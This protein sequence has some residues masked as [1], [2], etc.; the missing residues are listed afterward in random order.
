MTVFD[1]IW[2]YSKQ[3]ER[4]RDAPNAVFFAILILAIGTALSWWAGGWNALTIVVFT[5]FMLVFASLNIYDFRAEREATKRVEELYIRRRQQASSD[6][7][8]VARRDAAAGGRCRVRAGMSE[9]LRGGH[10][11]RHGRTPWWRRR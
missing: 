10:S 1:R 9:F 11:S 2:R 6:A 3:S 4:P 7:E 8:A 5:L